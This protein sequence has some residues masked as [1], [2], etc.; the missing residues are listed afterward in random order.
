VYTSFDVIDEN[1][2][3]VPHDS[4][5]MSVREIIDGHKVDIAEGENA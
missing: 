1:N 2:N 5:N 3:I 4:I